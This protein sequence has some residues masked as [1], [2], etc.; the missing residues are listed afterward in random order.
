[1]LATAGTPAPLV[2]KL[3]AE[4][5]A[6]VNDQKMRAMFAEE[7]ATPAQLTAPQFAELVQADA[8]KWKQVARDRNISIQ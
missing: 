7:S 8:A 5:R 2:E 4:I 1:M 3:N 6:I